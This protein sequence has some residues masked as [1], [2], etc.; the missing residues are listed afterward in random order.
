VYEV[1]S[2]DE[3][4]VT[5]RIRACPTVDVAKALTRDIL[6][7]FPP[8]PKKAIASVDFR[9]AQ[10]FTPEVTDVLL[11]LLKA[12]NPFVE[13]SAHILGADAGALFALQVERLVREAANP[14]RQVFRD[15]KLAL[16]YLTD[17][18]T[19]AQLAWLEKWYAAGDPN[20]MSPRP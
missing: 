18:L 14:R 19:A 4:I 10:I 3:R 6:G 12:D 9:C 2:H 7:A 20:R 1:L 5:L 16:A 8:R 15:P 11:A 17:A 13:K